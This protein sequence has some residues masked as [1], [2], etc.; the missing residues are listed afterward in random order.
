MTQHDHVW[1]FVSLGGG[2]YIQRCV[3]CGRK[4]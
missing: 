1:E 4:R 2:A 3:I